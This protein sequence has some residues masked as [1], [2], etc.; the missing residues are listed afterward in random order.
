MAY[1]G[2]GGELC[3]KYTFEYSPVE[4]SSRKAKKNAGVVLQMF[5]DERTQR[6]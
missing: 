4:G 5:E 2:G 3:M 6:S 1:R